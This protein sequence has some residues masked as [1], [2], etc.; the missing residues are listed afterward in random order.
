MIKLTAALVSAALVAGVVSLAASAT[1]PGRNGRMVFTAQVGPHTQLFTIEPDGRDLKQVTHFRDG[2]DSLNAN[3]SPDGARIV[4]ER[5]FPDQHAIVETMAFDGSDVMSL[6][7]KPARGTWL[8]HSSPSYSP[9]GRLIAFNRNIAYDPDNNGPR[10]HQEVWVMRV[11]GTGSRRVTPYGPV[12][13][14]SDHYPDKA[15]FSPDGKRIVFVKKLGRKSAGYVINADGTGLR[16]LTPYSLEID[17]RIDW[18]PDGSLI[19]FSNAHDDARGV[20]SN[21][22][23][24]R[25]NGTGLKQI[26]HERKGS[27]ISD[28]ADS[29]SPDGEQIMFVRDNGPT[30]TLFVMNADGSEAKQLTRGLNVHGGSWGTHR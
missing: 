25:P 1:A 29:W 7:P 17:D 2:S 12:G 20:V 15:G 30:S 14:N 8:W 9:D 4:F 23:T 13:P 21:V 28:K 10:D 24:I 16:Q 26:T 11:N 19:V 5:D 3:W 18:A 27:R 22:Y 6:T